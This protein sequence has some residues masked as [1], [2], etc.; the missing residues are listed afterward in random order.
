MEITR[1]T[2][3]TLESN[4]LAGKGTFFFLIWK[5]RDKVRAGYMYGRYCFVV[6]INGHTCDRVGT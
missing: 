2:Y 1:N 6:M 3:N 4:T 5:A